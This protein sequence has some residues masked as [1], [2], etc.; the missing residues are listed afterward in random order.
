MREGPLA[1]A[2]V[3]WCFGAL[4]TLMDV[5]E[6]KIMTHTTGVSWLA[7][8][9]EPG[10]LCRLAAALLPAAGDDNSVAAAAGALC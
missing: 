3:L 1:C 2:L 6:S 4:H 10:W 7:M 5:V 9:G 8:T